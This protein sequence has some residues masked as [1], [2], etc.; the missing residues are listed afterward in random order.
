M[1]M[2][3]KPHM[4]YKRKSFVSPLLNFCQTQSTLAHFSFKETDRERQTERPRQRETETGTERK[5][6]KK[7]KSLQVQYH[8]FIYNADVQPEKDPKTL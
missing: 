3:V 5:K 7:K 2:A 4:I 6:Q 8:D 1:C